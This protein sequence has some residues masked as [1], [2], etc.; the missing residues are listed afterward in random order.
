MEHTKTHEI[1]N[2]IIHTML[3]LGRTY[4]G[5]GE[6]NLRIDWFNKCGSFLT[7]IE[8]FDLKIERGEKLSAAEK[9]KHK[10]LIQNFRDT[11]EL[12]KSLDK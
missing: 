12:V 6:L 4:M 5:E 8:A 3:E 10:E 11:R 9:R 7:P 1:K 2:E